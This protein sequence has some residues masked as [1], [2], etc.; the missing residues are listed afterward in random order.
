MA[1]QT[2]YAA[3]S[4]DD[5]YLWYVFGDAYMDFPW[6]SAF[7]GGSRFES[8]WLTVRQFPW[9]AP[10]RM[11]HVDLGEHVTSPIG[12]YRDEDRLTFDL[13]GNYSTIVN[14]VEYVDSTLETETHLNHFGHLGFTSDGSFDS[15]KAF[16]G[17][18]EMHFTT[19]IKDSTLDLGAG[20]DIVSLDDHRDLPGTQYWSLIRRDY[21]Q[22]DLYS[23]IT[24]NRIRMEGGAESLIGDAGFRNYGEIEQIIAQVADPSEPGPTITFNP[25]S[26]TPGNLP[27]PGDRGLP[28]NIDLRTVEMVDSGAGYVATS[29]TFSDSFNLA[30]FN[31]IR[32]TSDNV[33]VGEATVHNGLT[34]AQELYSTP[35]DRTVTAAKYGVTAATLDEDAYPMLSTVLGTSRNGTHDLIVEEE[36]S[37]IAGKL[38]LY[39]MNVESELYNEFND[40]YLGTSD[41]DSTFLDGAEL[42]ATNGTSSAAATWSDRVALYGFGGNDSLT[43][44]FGR[45]YIFGGESTYNQLIGS[46]IG[47]RVAG[48]TGADYF[49]VGNT[50]S[51]GVTTGDNRIV[52]A[53][54]SGVSWEYSTDGWTSSTAGTTADW[55]NGVAAS[56]TKPVGSFEI[57]ETASGK[58]L[59]WFEQ[60]YA[61]DVISD[62]N[63]QEDTLVV[64]D[65][66]VAVISGL[67]N[68]DS[69]S[70]LSVANSIDL[71]S[72]TAIA[73]SDQGGDGARGGIYKQWDA[74]ADGVV[75][76]GN[77][78][79]FGYNIETLND[80]Y[81]NQG[82]RDAQAIA[83]EAAE[84]LTVRNSGTIVIRGLDGADVIYG[85]AGDDYIYGNQANN[86]VNISNGGNDRVYYDTFDGTASKH[87]VSGFTP[88]AVNGAEA[89]KFFLNKRV[90]DSFNRNDQYQ[91]TGRDIEITSANDVNANYVAARAYNP[92]VN[93]LHDPFYNPSIATSN[94]SHTEAD[95]RGLFSNEIDEVPTVSGSDGTSSYIG[96]G[97]V[98]AG[99]A[100]FAVPFVGPALGAAMIAT[101]ALL[102]GAGGV[103]N[104]TAHQNATYSG[105][106]SR[107]LNVLTDTSTNSGDGVLL[108]PAHNTSALDTSVRFLDFFQNVNAN[109]GYIPLVEFTANSGQGLYGYFALHSNTHTFVY[110]VASRDNLVENG[111]AMLVSQIQG[112]L[113]AQDFEVYDGA[114][115]IYN[116]KAG[117]EPE[118]I[119]RDPSLSSVEDTNGDDGLGVGRIDNA[120]NPILVTGTVNDDVPAGTFFRVYDGSKIIHDGRVVLENA[121]TTTAGS[122]VVTINSSSHGLAGDGQVGSDE[123][124]FDQDYVVN[125]ITLS[126]ATSYKVTR[127]GNDAFTIVATGQLASSSGTSSG[128]VVHSVNE[129]WMD[130]DSGALTFEFTDSR[131]LGTKV[132]NTT[133][134]EPDDPDQPDVV[135]DTFSL[136]DDRVNYTV[137]LVDGTTGIP[138]RDSSGAITIAGGNATIDGGDGSNDLLLITETSTFI[139]GVPDARLVGME[140]I[141]LAG[142]GETPSSINLDLRI[143]EE[144]FQITSGSAG[145]TVVGSKGNDT[146]FGLGGADSIWGFN[147]SDT[148]VYSTEFVPDGNG[149]PTNTVD[150]TAV[151][152]LQQDVT[153][154]GGI[155]TDTLRFDTD[156]VDDDSGNVLV[157]PAVI[158]GDSA[159]LKVSEFERLT[160]NG[161]GTQ[162]V[163]L[164]VNANAAF[165]T[166][167]WVTTDA[168]ATS[169]DFDAS[170]AA[171]T[172]NAT[173]TG[174]D[175]GD[176]IVSGSGDDSLTGG[177]GNDTI[178]GGTGNDT[179][180]GGAGQ[181]RLT[182]DGGR[183]TFVW[184]DLTYSTS[185]A[186]DTITDFVFNG[187]SG[188]VLDIT[189][190][191]TGN[192]VAYSNYQFASYADMVSFATGNLS[193]QTGGT[194]IEVFVGRVGSEAYVIANETN[195]TGG[196]QG[197]VDLTGTSSIANLDADSFLG[198]GDIYEVTPIFW[199]QFASP[200]KVATSW[201]VS[202]GE[203]DVDT[204]TYG[205]VELPYY[206]DVGRELTVSGETFRSSFLLFSF[207]D[208][209]LIDADIWDDEDGA[210][211][212][213]VII[214]SISAQDLS[215]DP[216]GRIRGGVESDIKGETTWFDTNNGNGIFLL[217]FDTFSQDDGGLT[218]PET[219]LKF[220]FDIPL[221]GGGVYNY[222]ADIIIDWATGT[223]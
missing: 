163:T 25:G 155:G 71:R 43:G 181:D 146:I 204:I 14:N 41:P 200:V 9:S 94:L 68:G 11:P 36:D 19:A 55:A 13:S 154:V 97:M 136:T 114:Y 93:F 66:G 158:I 157:N 54:A 139:N 194:D 175:G 144:G 28:S 221:N 29:Q 170:D 44:G 47:N 197:R 166:G 109:D 198:E 112:L 78:I 220:D 32:Y 59:S 12:E 126:S 61:T 182:G 84:D 96:L 99:R 223:A 3:R 53:V 50:S 113:S 206:K 129:D 79:V 179:I 171:W 82:V 6:S 191:T 35:N 201:F 106:V 167:I 132:I 122:D 88:A 196:V 160:L 90:V 45:D 15:L 217:N 135:D 110:L 10:G 5:Y 153:I 162:E 185:A 151:Q 8:Q 103:V 39:T 195:L 152:Q 121:F 150:R 130:F 174:T 20:W 91:Y 60:G 143:Q 218:Q 216:A 189:G 178:S 95:G 22:V 125:G 219:R 31:F 186:P 111:E 211:G 180:D 98:I 168:D 24:G 118:V 209:N 164:G 18:H 101:G 177:A 184:D 80:V 42:Y 72:Y 187:A 17:N 4:I 23:L 73:T 21:N 56:F 67:R 83:N 172:R 128:T 100:L 203:Y 58:A 70:A 133:N 119:L 57:R 16:V 169:L 105:D 202:L 48:G 108:K 86:S 124:K 37:V 149:D 148:V 117:G 213:P 165:A 188:D 1:F 147:G 156:R 120:V 69:V 7:A 161:T 52:V 222:V 65:N 33:W 208:K 115:D 159:F 92:G 207:E 77:Q 46:A 138:T 34:G 199:D 89:D 2:N 85:S 141:L 38:R 27:N 75:S 142:S 214:N 145:D 49:G 123:I 193:A 40:V 76:G 137:E 116:Y 205:G 104:T 87:F 30:Y 215:G 107:Y 173:V 134:N 183:D 102:G 190:L 192:D 74:E 51:A 176:T 63:A 64:L 131:S 127:V 140:T 81:T 26:R 62:W 210:F 212:P